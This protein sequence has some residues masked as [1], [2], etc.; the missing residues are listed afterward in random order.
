MLNSFINSLNDAEKVL[1]KENLLIFDKMLAYMKECDVPDQYIEE[2]SQTLL[3]IFLKAENEGTPVMEALGTDDYK[4]YCDFMYE[5]QMGSKTRKQIFL[6][7]SSMVALT[8]SLFTLL[9]YATQTLFTLTEHRAFSFRY[10][11]SYGILIQYVVISIATVFAF[12]HIHKQQSMKKSKT[13]KA[14]DILF[15]L[16]FCSIFSIFEI[17][18]PLGRNYTFVI[19]PV[20]SILVPSILLYLGF[21]YYQRRYRS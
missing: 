12:L 20:Y 8:I 14:N 19:L 16:V 9:E 1:S 13:S 7:L 15:I 4:A 6:R 17:S 10:T 2:S 3:K 21:G 18:N 5:K 11:I